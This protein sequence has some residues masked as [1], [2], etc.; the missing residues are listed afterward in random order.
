MPKKKRRIIPP[1][2]RMSILDEFTGKMRQ[3]HRRPSPEEL[4]QQYKHKTLETQVG[5][6]IKDLELKKKEL[7][8]WRSTELKLYLYDN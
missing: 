1:W 2:L 8:V 5:I 4:S 7:M 3:F 6:D